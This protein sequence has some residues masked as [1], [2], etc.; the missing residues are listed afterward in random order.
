M[1]PEGKRR[2]DGARRSALAQQ[3]PSSRQRPSLVST[4][5]PKPIYREVK[6]G[7]TLEVYSTAGD[8]FLA[9][10]FKVAG[11]LAECLQKKPSCAIALSGG[12]TPRRLYELL[13][14]GKGG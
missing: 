11:I 14:Q 7:R 12:S 3:L 1:G 4:E 10:A 5:P 13:A 6:S 8:L 2:H 9:A